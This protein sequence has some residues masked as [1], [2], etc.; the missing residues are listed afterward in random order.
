MEVLVAPSH[1]VV[2]ETE[3]QG[4]VVIARCVRDLLGLIHGS[5]Q[6]SIWRQRGLVLPILLLIV[7]E[8]CLKH[9]LQIVSGIRL[10][11]DLVRVVL[12]LVMAELDLS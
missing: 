6:I 10:L 9:V 8:P 5:N 7:R 4:V 3:I 11:V 12:E 1:C 2:V